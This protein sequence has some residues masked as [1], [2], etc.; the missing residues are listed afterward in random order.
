MIDFRMTH[1]KVLLIN[2]TTCMCELAKNLILSGVNL[3]LFDFNF[4]K[5]SLI[6]KK[7]I[8]TNFFFNHTELNE[9]VI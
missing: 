9:E 6:T 8:E 2:L 1:S 4:G 5:S 7:D 3:F